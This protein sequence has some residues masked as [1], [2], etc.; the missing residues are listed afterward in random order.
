MW[1]MV[2]K[3]GS[4]LTSTLDGGVGTLTPQPGA[5]NKHRVGIWWPQSQS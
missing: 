4:L 5:L 1:E 2:V 3:L